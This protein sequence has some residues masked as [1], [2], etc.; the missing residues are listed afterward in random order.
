M[1]ASFLIL[2]REG[3]EAA[4]V[5]AIVLGYLARVGKRRESWAVWTGVGLAALIAFA[6]A[7]GGWTL[8][9]RL[10]EEPEE[11]AEAGVSLA[12]AAVL[13]W[14]VFWMRNQ[15]RQVRSSIEAKAAR[16]LERGSAVG[17]ASISFF[18]VL[19]EG[20]ETAL[21]LT[22]VGGMP[23][24]RAAGGLLGL[25]T[26]IF[27]GYLVYRG[28]ARMNLRAFFQVTGGLVLLLAAGLL[29]KGVGGLQDL[30]ALASLKNPLFDLSSLPLVGSGQVKSLLSA[31][32]GWNPKPSLEVVAAYLAYAIAVGISYFSGISQ[33]GRPRHA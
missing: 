15:A 9:E 11:W 26:A 29:A 2:L 32:F 16:A 19:R 25:A 4:L 21:F 23:W 27:L 8:L 14:M 20:S 6:L 33:A 18:A 24:E 3:M 10:A 22:A 1:G 17:L 7:L 28:G 5:V 12:A 31:L 13:T 30:G